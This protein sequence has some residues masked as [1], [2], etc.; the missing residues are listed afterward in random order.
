MK[1]KK[2]RIIILVVIVAVIVT[3]W[4]A[5]TYIQSNLEALSDLT[6]SSVDLSKMKDGTYEGSYKAFPVEAVVD[7]KISNHAIVGIDLVKHI[8][9]QGGDAEVIPDK[10]I[11]AQSLEVDFISGATYSSKVILKAIEDAFIKANKD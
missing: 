1:K 10:V 2:V 9:G 6:I 3:A 11:E 5:A 7:V 4:G 8:N